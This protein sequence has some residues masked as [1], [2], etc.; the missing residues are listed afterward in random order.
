MSARDRLRWDAIY[1]ET[2][3][4]VYPAPDPLLFQYTPPLSDETEQRAMDLAAGLGQNGLWLAAQGY[5][6][7]VADISRVALT[8][9]QAEAVRRGLRNLNFLQLDLDDVLLPSET[10]HVLCVFRYLKRDIFPQIRA[11]VRPGGRVIYETYN[12][13]YL[14]RVRDFNRAY[15]LEPGELAG[16][17]AD[18]RI[19]FNTD[20]GHTSQLVARKPEPGT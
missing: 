19:L 12:V 3:E 13:R 8:R 20:D 11:A 7:D 9:S 6:T 2:Q 5:L 16:Y 18:W 15:L 10:Y 14:E 1:R 17:F 4:A